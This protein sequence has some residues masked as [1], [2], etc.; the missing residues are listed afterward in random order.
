MD[1]EP[2]SP[3]SAATGAV[4]SPELLHAMD[5][6]WRAANYL[7]VGQ[8]YLY[9]NPLLTKPLE[10]AHVKPLIVGHWGTTPGQNLVESEREADRGR[11]SEHHGV[12]RRRH[13]EP[14]HHPCAHHD[15]GA[16]RQEQNQGRA[17]RSKAQDE[18][19][20]GCRDGDFLDVPQVA[21]VGGD[22]VVEDGGQAG[23]CDGD[24]AVRGR[25]GGAVGDRGHLLRPALPLGKI[26]LETK[27]EIGM[28][29][30]ALRILRQADHL[31]GP[32]H[33]GHRQCRA[34]H[35]SLVQALLGPQCRGI[36]GRVGPCSA[37]Y[38]LT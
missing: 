6:Y 9:D 18:Q 30:I 20:H 21:Q 31:T 27:Q 8:L 35:C 1:V 23:Q 10:L 5:A 29:R 19:Q 25:V 36:K 11:H 15:A 13:C 33:L 37:P 22:H 26:S 2:L 16:R 34:G 17:D 12:E 32:G 7:S 3:S 4:L 28:V 14:R 38:R 24:A